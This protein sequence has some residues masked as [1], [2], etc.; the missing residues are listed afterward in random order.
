MH[1]RRRSDGGGPTSRWGRRQFVASGIALGGTALAGCL[2]DTAD[3]DDNSSPGGETI[4]P[5]LEPAGEIELDAVPE[6]VFVAFPQYADMAVALGH[7][8]TVNSLFSTEM[9]GTTMNRFYDHLPGVSFD[10]ESL[11]D[12]LANELQREQLYELDSDI[13]FLDPSYVVKHDSDWRASDIDDIASTVGPWMGNFHSGVHSEPAD[14]YADQYEYYTLWEVFE[15]VAEIFQE[16]ERYEALEAVY[17]D[18]RDDIESNLP[19]ADERPTAARVTLGEGEF[20]AYHLNESGYW[21]AD[22]RPLAAR[23]ALADHS[24]SGDWGVVDYETMIDIDPDVILHLWGITP[25]YSIDS[26]RADLADH[27]IGSRL[28]AVETDR[29][30]AGGMRY[31]GPLMTLFQLEMTA[32]QLY[33]DQF[34]AWPTYE[35]GDPYPEIPADEQLFDRDRVAGIVTGEAVQ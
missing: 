24:W 10:W 26:V 30:V 23:D 27:P 12:P 28:S 5:H 7:G 18:L 34:G 16:R 25:Q 20:F 14:A 17:E 19:P 29:V 1:S 3:P 33:P 2:S 22:T 32:K 13:H 15:Q 11:P 8:D 35:T 6:N 4:S 21:Q 9:S 31:Q